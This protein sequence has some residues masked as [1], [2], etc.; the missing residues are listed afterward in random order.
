MAKESRTP[1]LNSEDIDA[2]LEA[3]RSNGRP[4]TTDE[5]V[6]ALRTAAASR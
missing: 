3:L 5:L 1:Q 2:L 4:M 6:E